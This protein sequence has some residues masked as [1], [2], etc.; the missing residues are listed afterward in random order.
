MKNTESQNLEGLENITGHH[1][2]ALANKANVSKEYVR[3][4]V[5]GERETNSAVAKAIMAAA[6]KLNAAIAK[7]IIK[8]ERELI[9]IGEND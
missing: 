2:T 7:G 5:T 9:I 8:A 1:I 4:I 6:K 3:L